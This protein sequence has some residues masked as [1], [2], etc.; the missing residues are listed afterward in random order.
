MRHLAFQTDHL[1]FVRAQAE[2]KQR[3]IGFSVEDPGISHSIY[4]HDPDGYEIEITTYEL[5]GSG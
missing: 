3:G 4:F 1:N 5:E 2:L